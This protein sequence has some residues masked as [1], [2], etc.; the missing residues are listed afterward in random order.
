MDDPYPDVSGQDTMSGIDF[1]VFI[2]TSIF[3]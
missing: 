2:W 1:L 3:N